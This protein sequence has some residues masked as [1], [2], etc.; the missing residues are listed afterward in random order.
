MALVTGRT[1]RGPVPLG[2]A[3]DKAAA[4]LRRRGAGIRVDDVTASLLGEDFD[5]GEGVLLGK[6]ESDETRTLLGKRT[7]TL[8]RRE[9]LERI[10]SAF[11]RCAQGPRASALVVSGAAGMGKSRIRREIVRSLRARGE[12]PEV[13]MARANPLGAGSAFA[14]AAQ[15][16]RR[17]AGVLAGE[18]HA[19]ARDKL[20]R[21]VKRY[22]RAE[23][24]ARVA[25]FL[26]EL[27][28]APSDTDDDVT[29]A[30]ARREPTVMF[31][32]IRIAW[33]D[34][35][36]AEC[37]VRPL[38]IVLDDLQWGDQPTVTLLD[39][40]LR[41]SRD[42]PLFVLAFGRPEAA[43]RFPALW[44]ERSPEHL[45]LGDMTREGAASLVAYALGGK[46]TDAVTN[47]LV[48]RAAGNAFYLEELIRAVAD[49]RDETPDTALL[50]VQ[51]RLERL[52]PEA[53]RVLRA[54]SVF[55]RTFW[56][57]GVAALV[58]DADAATS[59]LGELVA[60][61]LV[62][63]R[64]ASKFAGA[65][66][67]AFNHLLVQEAAH[68]ML[69]GEDKS[70][71]HGL[72][73]EWL[74]GAGE[75]DAMVLAEHWELAGEPAQA[76]VAWTHAAEQ[77]LEG[78]DY[79]ACA[80]RAERGVRCR[81]RGDALA[82]LRDLQAEAHRWLGDNAAMAARAREAT[83][84]FTHG[85]DKWADS[86]SKLALAYQRL[87]RVTEVVSI[88][89]DI[90]ASVA[91]GNA[92]C[93]AA[94]ARTASVLALAGRRDD[95]S[96]LLDA[97]IGAVRPETDPETLARLDQACA[98]R[99][100]FEGR[101]AEYVERSI[102][103]ANAFSL[104]GDRRLACVAQLNVGHGML[105][106][107]LNERAAGVLEAT[108]V[109][110]ERL[111]LR[112]I[113]TAAAQN[114]GWAVFRLGNVARSLELLEASASAFAQQGNR[115]L[116]GFSHVLIARVLLERELRGARD[117]ADRAVAFAESAPPLR[118]AALAV[119][120]IIHV[121]IGEHAAAVAAAREAMAGLEAH[122]VEEGEGFI[123]LACAEALEAGGSHAE[124]EAVLRRA[125]ARVVERAE[126]I[127]RDDWRS[128]FL[129]VPEHAAVLSSA[130]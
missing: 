95:A 41:A 35:I 119:M 82:R 47:R 3:L 38:V 18:P 102:S 107:G 88:G 34:F 74:V 125:G 60:R 85:T 46:A 40:A 71:G 127:H 75:T 123:R 59:Q 100:L 10:E 92:V 68:A 7:P 14:L 96:R 113:A 58:G 28:S 2:D 128:S 6:R 62:H 97:A 70:L 129:A 118:I 17:A 49:G 111:G 26:A 1:E 124:A 122:G 103:A 8:G 109:D 9:E 5:V 54:A 56:D 61:E 105:E 44:A 66:E 90:A 39:S 42:L 43:E 106:L 112:G 126:A 101:T 32:Q 50:I 24:V 130:P 16:V 114:L 23:D 36:A 48:E 69:V 91:G 11:A 72:A 33:E 65:G 117:A 63:R 89:D 29:L 87:G 116:E 20:R 67:L 120:A 94:A 37:A 22:V 121:R 51:S 78:N 110:A 76:L 45:V 13:W 15:L 64:R 81:A 84:L 12:R 86:A 31:D 108:V 19:V 99:A 98:N 115:R 83:Q 25:R 73:A 104:A 79:G 77:A 57:A 27:A 30:T 53:R 52:A 93:I 4:L 55:G 21:R 80:L